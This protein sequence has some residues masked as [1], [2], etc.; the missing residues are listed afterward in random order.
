[1]SPSVS[2]H[3]IGV[4]CVISE[5]FSFPSRV[6]QIES[7]ELMPRGPWASPSLIIISKIPQTNCTYTLFIVIREVSLLNT[8][9]SFAQLIH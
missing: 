2:I 5:P 1:M 4:K 7:H 3:L 8:R 9:F 6:H